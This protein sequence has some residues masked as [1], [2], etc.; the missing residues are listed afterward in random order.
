MTRH[1]RLAFV[2]DIALGDHPK[3]VGFGLHSRYPRGVPIAMAGRILPPGPRP[4]LV[5]GN[6]EFPLG[7]DGA[8]G[9]PH[10]QCRGSDEHAAFL[11]AAGISVLN[12][13]N[14]HSAQHG[15]DAFWATAARLR[16]SGLKVVGVPS[17]FD[18]A[19]TI[20][21]GIS[22]ITFLG[23][24]DRPRQYAAETPP[25]NEFGEHA[26]EQIR[27]ARRRAGIV[28][29]SIHWGEEFVQ[30][31]MARE[32]RIA[33]AMI[34]AGATIVV[35]HHPHVLREVERYGDGI[36]AYSLG[37]FI[38]DMTWNAETRLGGCLVIEMDGERVGAHRLA[39][40]HIAPD[41]LP[42]YLSPSESAIAVDRMERRRGEQTVAVQRR[43]YCAL[44]AS[45]HRRQVR[46]TVM[47]MARNA[48]RYSR[49][50]FLAMVAG[51]I[52]NRVAPARP[53][54]ATGGPP[55]HSS[56]V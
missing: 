17:D 40:S 1:M 11:A 4:D 32:R 9:A 30:I 22:R 19:P 21:D 34:D 26:Y 52:R 29:A 49:G 8:V 51:A 16:R 41:Y 18:E 15:H 54:A 47:M 10:A 23:W 35:G 48:H 56:D 36:I 12:V 13:A 44:V 24:S 45:E 28:V 55:L 50:T 6:F 3:T 43:G 42:T 7:A 14:N 39:L 27:A 25:Y 53:I 20:D 33:R 37:N 38:G 31:P 2:G 46:T 5:F